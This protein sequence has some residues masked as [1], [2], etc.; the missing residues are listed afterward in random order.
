MEKNFKNFCNLILL[1]RLGAR[2]GSKGRTGP[3]ML[4]RKILER[5]PGP[6]TA[7]LLLTIKFKIT[8]CWK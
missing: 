5:R 4:A 3:R 2:F 7:I 6:K 8:C 1:T